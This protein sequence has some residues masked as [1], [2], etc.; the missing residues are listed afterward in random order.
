MSSPNDATAIYS[1][2]AAGVGEADLR[3][4]V[5]QGRMLVADPAERDSHSTGLRGRFP[6][7]PQ[8]F[9]GAR[10]SS[11]TAIASRVVSR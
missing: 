6:L 5:A 1:P 2:S 9:R 3:S 8:L 10:G 11:A 7:T 4:A